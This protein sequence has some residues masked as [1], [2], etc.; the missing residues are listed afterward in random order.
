MEWFM[1]SGNQIKYCVENLSRKFINPVKNIREKISTRIMSLFD[2]KYY[3]RF[4]NLPPHEKSGIWKADQLIGCEDG[5]SVYDCCIE[6]G[7]CKLVIP[8]P[9]SVSSLYTIQGFILYDKRRVY[10]VSG[11]NVG[12]GTDNEP[13]IKNVKIE[14]EITK[15]IYGME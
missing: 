5:V 1:E 9:L 11:I 13:V 14:R 6:D 8:T 7:K 2:K 4:G 3:I 10:L 12:T 15:E